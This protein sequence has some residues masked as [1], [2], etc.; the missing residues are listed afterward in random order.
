MLLTSSQVSLAASSAIVLFFTTALFL[1]GCVIQQRTLRDLRAAI[2]DNGGVAETRPSPKIFLPDRF[3]Q[4]TTELEDGTVIALDPADGP[5]PDLTRPP[6]IFLSQDSQ[7]KAFAPDSQP[8][9]PKKSV[10]NE[11]Q[12]QSDRIF[13]AAGKKADDKSP[14]KSGA[15]TKGEKAASGGPTSAGS[16]TKTEK[17]I[18]RAERRRRIREDIQRLA[19]GSKPVF[20]Q[21][22]LW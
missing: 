12:D 20:Y 2:R 15:A 19:Q 13:G 7:S 10:V 8:S 22:R 18:S 14:S 17:P 6:Q 9:A 4:L 16:K 21:R 3:K 11:N 5:L 1:S